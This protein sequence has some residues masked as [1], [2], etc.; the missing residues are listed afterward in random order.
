[1]EQKLVEERKKI[2]GKMAEVRHKIMVFSNKGGVGKTTL[3]VNLA[4]GLA[5][6]GYNVGLMDA[7]FHG[8]NIPSMLGL[9]DRSVLTKDGELIPV[10]LSWG[11]GFLKI[12]SLAFLVEA[13]SAVV[14]R[15]MLK[16]SVINQLLGDVRWG[17]LDYLIMDM[18]PGISDEP[19][20][21]AQLGH[22]NL[23]HQGAH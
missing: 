10:S 16:M 13:G 19:L 9:G 2:D 21:I 18:P 7:D 12:I 1:M 6:L 4:F 22:H 15:G 11:R 3:S 14:W 17:N 23:L 8:P 20:N 5:A